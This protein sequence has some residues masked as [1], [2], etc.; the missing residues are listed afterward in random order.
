MSTNCCA[1]HIRRSV[2]GGR[3]ESLKRSNVSC[4][5]AEVAISRA[6]SPF[7]VLLRTALPRLDA[8]RASKWGAALEF[9]DHHKV[10]S[11]G[12]SAFCMLLV[13]LRVLPAGGQSC[14]S[15]GEVVLHLGMPLRLELQRRARDGCTYC[16]ITPGSPRWDRPLTTIAVEK[17]RSPIACEK[18]DE[19]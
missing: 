12:L 9:A 14:A 19:V 13:G 15:R 18:N 6:S 11:K 4:A 7:L 2:V 8:K 5:E 16:H 10:R 17:A 3:T 1:A